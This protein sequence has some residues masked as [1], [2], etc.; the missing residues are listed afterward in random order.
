MRRKPESPAML[1]SAPRVSSA[2]GV[3]A[4]KA[5]QQKLPPGATWQRSPSFLMQKPHPLRHCSDWLYQ[6]QRVSRQMLPP[7]VAMLR[8]T[9]DATVLTASYNT[10]QRCAMTAECSSVESVVRAPIA[11][12]PSD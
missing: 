2:A 7:S 1:I 8:I 6:R 9:G 5:A 4:E 11:S 3:S 10:R 12:P